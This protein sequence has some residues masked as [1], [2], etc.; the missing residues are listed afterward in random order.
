MGLLNQQVGASADA[1]GRFA[2]AMKSAAQDMERGNPMLADLVRG[3]G[4]IDG[5]DTD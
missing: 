1:A 3:S 5:D 2:S 4:W